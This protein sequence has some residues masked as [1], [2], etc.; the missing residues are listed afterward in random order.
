[1]TFAIQQHA[2]SQ[3]C[4]VAQSM[5]TGPGSS[6]VLWSVYVYTGDSFSVIALATSAESNQA[7]ACTI[8]PSELQRVTHANVLSYLSPV[9]TG[10]EVSPF[11]SYPSQAPFPNLIKKKTND[12]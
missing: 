9:C 6:A 10:G 2:H 3:S 1:M 7:R 11:A 8:T 4:I 12:R 5:P